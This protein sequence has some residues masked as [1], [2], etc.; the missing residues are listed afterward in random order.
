MLKKGI[1]LNQFPDF[2]SK[3]N[4]FV[5]DMVEINN[6]HYQLCT[7]QNQI[8][9]FKNGKWS[10]VQEFSSTIKVKSFTLDKRLLLTT[11]TGIFE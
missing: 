2:L 8:I 6:G 3:T 1:Y 9:E 4:N 10:L 5:L 11:S 7:T